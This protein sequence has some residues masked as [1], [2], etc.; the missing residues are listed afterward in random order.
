MNMA[1]WAE[2]Q[3]IENLAVLDLH[4]PDL[5]DEDDLIE[6]YTSRRWKEARDLMKDR[7]GLT[8][9]EKL[10]AGLSLVAA[11]ATALL[12]PGNAW[13]ATRIVTAF[14]LAGA[15]IG[16]FFPGLG[17]A[18]GFNVGAMIGTVVAGVW[19]YGIPIASIALGLYMIV[20][21]VIDIATG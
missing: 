21:G 20:D 15:Y 8:G 11:G 12:M 2:M 5:V 10:D 9:R 3:P 18:I 6:R 19:V 4:L 13:A 16:S 7:S 14:A 17:T 1:V